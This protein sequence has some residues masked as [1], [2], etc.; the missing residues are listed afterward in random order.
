MGS[1]ALERFLK[2]QVA[3]IVQ[4]HGEKTHVHQVQHAMFGSADVHIN[5]EPLVHQGWI[6]RLRLVVVRKVAQ[7]VPGGVQEVIADV[8]FAPGRSATDGAGG[9]NEA[10]DCRE[11]RNAS[12][13]GHPV[14]HVWQEHRQLLL[15][16]GNGSMLLAVDDRN[17]WPP[18]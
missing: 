16:Y 4:R 12:T 1:E 13:R 8:R 17:G 6:P 14:L 5:R 2:L 9:V 3:K 18:V 15:R 10:L 7:E 11:R